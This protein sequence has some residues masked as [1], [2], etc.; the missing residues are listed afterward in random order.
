MITIKEISAIIAKKKKLLLDNPDIGYD[1]SNDD[2]VTLVENE[3]TLEIES[4]VFKDW[5]SILVTKNSIVLVPPY[6]C[7][8]TLFAY[9]G[10]NELLK[11]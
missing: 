5:A 11:L 10:W 9:Q 2:N 8:E 6:G 4:I 3:G 7:R 1:V